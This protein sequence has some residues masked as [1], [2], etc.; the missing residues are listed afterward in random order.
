MLR[1]TCRSDNQIDYLEIQS[2]D[3]N[4][5]RLENK[6]D[7][8]VILTTREL[9][10]YFSDWCKNNKTYY[11]HTEKHVMDKSWVKSVKNS[12]ESLKTQKL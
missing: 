10:H 8:Q 9:K 1:Y 7:K 5:K 12:Q 6:I 11:S 3:T 4:T 2:P